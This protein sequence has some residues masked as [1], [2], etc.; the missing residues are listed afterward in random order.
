MRTLLIVLGGGGHTEQM[1]R[2]VEKLGDNYNY[3][4][5]TISGD[6][7]SE[8]RLKKTGK[9]WKIYN[10]RKKSDK[11]FF[12]VFL[13]YIPSSIQALSLLSKTKADTI[14]ASGTAFSANLCILGKLLFRKK[15]IF[16]ESWSRVY[17]K[18]LAGR[19]VYPFSNLFFVQWPSQL[20]NYKKAIYAGRLG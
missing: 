11:G 17:S 7:L 10:P 15:I 14:I 20:K 19:F 16:L 8:K 6:K 4:Y 2:L 13:K 5:V 3:E 12:K 1:T 18:S 9:F